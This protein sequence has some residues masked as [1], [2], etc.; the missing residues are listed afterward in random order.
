MTDRKRAIGLM[1]GTSM[2]GIDVALI[3]TDGVGDVER[4][5]AS[6]TAYKPEFR[7]QLVDAVQL[8]QGLTGRAQRP[9]RLAEIERQLTLQH[10]TVVQQFLKQQGLP[11]TSIDVIG[12]HGQTVLH[13]P[14]QRLTVQL[15]DG[16]LLAAQTGID[17][18]Y[19]LRAADCAAGGQGA[20]LVPV[21]HRAL[22]AK[23]PQ[24]PLAIINIGG[25]ANVTYVGRDGSLLAFDTGPGN[26]MLDDWMLRHTGQALDKDGA[27]AASGHVD[28]DVIRFYLS[29]SFFGSAPPKSLDRNAFP[30]D[31]VDHLSVADGAATLTAF[32]AS[33]IAR[34]RE[35]MPQEPQLW[36]ICGGGRRNR[37]LMSA[38]AARVENAVVPA[39]AVG[40]DG[41]ATEAEAWAYLAVRSLSGLPIT[42]PGTTGVDQPMTGGVLAEARVA[43]V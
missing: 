35:H 19:D 32:A 28:E 6:S 7:N 42:F 4:I 43:K 29:Q 3:E 18:V 15:G 2:D 8:A 17:V 20:P 27:M 24:R 38:I 16:P 10:A 25:V 36:V 37:T 33:A 26:A 14:D 41:D 40:F 23:L 1:S 9:G 12:F 34:S 21:Y 39:E 22:A 11:A 31:L 13:R 30:I 5:A